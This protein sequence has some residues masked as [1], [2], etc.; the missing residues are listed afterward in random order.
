MSLLRNRFFLLSTL[1]SL[2]VIVSAIILEK[3]WLLALPIALMLFYIAVKQPSF[4]GILL[5]I[6]VAFSFPLSDIVQDLSFDIFLISE[7][8]IIALLFLL[9]VQL[10]YTKKID[11][12]FIKHPVTIAIMIYL[13]W[14]L[15]T[16]LSS[17]MI[18]VSLKHF[19]TRFWFI[20]A[21]YY[22]FYHLY[23]QKSDRITNLI[24]TFS[25]S[26]LL[27]IFYAIGREYYYNMEIKKIAY[28]AANPF[29]KDHTSYGATLAIYLPFLVGFSFN[30][31]IS[32]NKR[33][34]LKIITFI[35][36]VGIVLSYT[37][38]A[39]ASLLGAA[40]IYLIIRLKIKPYIYITA[41]LLLAIAIQGSIFSIV[42]QNKQESSIELSEHFKSI[43]NITNDMSNLERIN[44]WKCAY[45]MFEEKPFLGFGPGTYTFNYAPYQMYSDKTPISTNAGDMGNAHSEYLGA[46]AESGIFG[47]ITFLAIIILT[48]IKAIKLYY[49]LTDKKMKLWVICAFIGLVSYYLHGLVN[50]F[51]DTDKISLPFWSFLAIIVYVDIQSKR[52]NNPNLETLKQE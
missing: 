29:Y 6:S 8:L 39:W 49:R 31:S 12:E 52:V 32:K 9:I 24:I 22:F 20:T 40:V 50:N 26:T 34:I 5:V 16:S 27:V 19:A 14:T 2:I 51:L 35:F 38:A 13:S 46:L 21:F 48:S 42:K 4:F 44:R 45:K 15:V 36:I 28:W 47:L 30:K 37:R 25:I 7:I 18:L 11:N 41:I 23:A 17:T 43:S 33:F 1:L 10:I 3:F